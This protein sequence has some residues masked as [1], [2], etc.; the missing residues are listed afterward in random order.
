VLEATLERLSTDLAR[1]GKKRLLEL[2]LPEDVYETV[3]GAQAIESPRA[4][5]R[6]LRL[7]RQ[8]LRSA[9]WST[10][11]ARLA[12]LNDHGSLP[13]KAGDDQGIA[14]EAAWV[15]RLVGE[16]GAGMDAF[17]GE[18]PRADRTYLRQLVRAVER[19]SGDRRL[20]A[21]RKL[22]SAVRGHLAGSRS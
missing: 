1:L 6:Q 21:E 3:L 14:R 13:V 17:L 2:G 16:G 8:A 11:H 18:F 4:K 19:S 10:I 22:R 5:G 7:V 9:D 12:T 15:A 20:K